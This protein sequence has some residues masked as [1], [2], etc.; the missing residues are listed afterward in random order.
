MLF[1]EAAFQIQNNMFT[2]QQHLVFQQQQQQQNEDRY[3]NEIKR[4]RMED[5]SHL[6]V[7]RVCE[8]KYGLK[9]D[10]IEY[11]E[12]DFVCHEEIHHQKEEEF[13]NEVQEVVAQFAA[14]T[15][16]EVDSRVIICTIVQVREEN[17]VAVQEV[18]AVQEPPLQVLGRRVILYTADNQ[19]VR[20]TIENLFDLN[21]ERAIQIQ[22]SAGEN[23][24]FT[25]SQLIGL[26]V[27]LNPNEEQL[28][29]IA[30]SHHEVIQIADD[31]S[32]AEDEDQHEV[33][34]ISEDDESD[35]ST[36]DDTD[37]Y[38]DDASEADDFPEVEFQAARQ[39]QAARPESQPARRPEQQEPQQEPQQE[40]DCCAICLDMTDAARNFVSLDCGHQFHFACIMG[41]MAN[42]GQNRNQCPMCRGA[43]VQQYDVHSQESMDEMVE[44]LARNNQHLQDEL[45][46]NRQHREDLTEEYVRVMTMNMQ[47]SMRHREEREARD[48]L[49]RRAYMCGLNERIAAVVL[50]AA[51]NDISQNYEHGGVR[52]HIERQVRDLCMSFGMMAYDA[53]YDDPQDQDQYQEDQDQQQEDQGQYQEDLMNHEIIEVD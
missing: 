6:K 2:E 34:Q 46:L 26:E 45:D 48:A 12:D 22:T 29:P 42:G 33:V 20:G 19:T 49:E 27:L 38:Q 43:V 5:G 52:V 17:E 10:A 50:S 51:N 37:Q 23:L 1:V 16:S 32:E 4:R 24:I 3:G 30:S 18:Q 14:L 21:G 44:R 40:R 47:I 53:Q 11:N 25:S 13:N 7:W 41:N 39:F 9:E 35:A 15:I 36:Q 28:S 31:A 8:F